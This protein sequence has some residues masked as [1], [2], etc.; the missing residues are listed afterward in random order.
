MDMLETFKQ[1]PDARQAAYSKLGRR[2]AKSTVPAKVMT[3]YNLEKADEKKKF[4]FLCEFMTVCRWEHA[5]GEAIRSA[6]ACM[7]GTPMKSLA[8]KMMSNYRL[9]LH[10]SWERDM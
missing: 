3:R 5:I 2:I 9:L 4:I 10:V 6:K 1:D 8:Q 7:A